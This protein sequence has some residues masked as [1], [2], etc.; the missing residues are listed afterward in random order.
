MSYS[1]TSWFVEQAALEN[2]PVK[3]TF[4][5]AGSDYSDW[6]LSWPTINTRWDE[7][8]PNNVTIQLANEDQTFNFF[9]TAKTNVQ[10]ACVVK[11]GFT[12]PTSGD[13]LLTMFN[14]TVAEVSFKD[15]SVSLRLNDKVQKLSGPYR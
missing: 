15:A 5:I 14:G 4:T 13:E 2:P 1:V 12:H 7:L 3:R 10:A 8:R 11:L 9:K 6:V